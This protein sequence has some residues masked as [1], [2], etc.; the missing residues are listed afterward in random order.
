MTMDV[1]EGGGSLP[2]GVRVV[3]SFVL[4]ETP[5]DEAARAIDQVLNS[6]VESRIVL[7]DNSPEP[8][9]PA[10]PGDARVTQIHAGANLGYGAGHNRAMAMSAGWAPYHFV[11][12]TDLLYGPEVIPA[13]L[14][15]LDVHPEVGLAMP[16]VR[17]PDGRV[18]HLCRLLPHPLDVFGRGFASGSAWTRRR[19][20]RYE[21][22]QW[23]YDRPAEFPFL[24]G[25]FM[26]MRRDVV[27]RVG[28]FDDRFFMYGEDVDLS[29]RIHAIAR[30]MF[31]P[32]ACVA[33]DYRSQR[34]RSLRRT[35]YK[36][37]NLSRYF[38]KWGWFF[39]RNRDAIN[40]RTVA[41][42]SAPQTPKA[43]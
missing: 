15:F 43:S 27:D 29:R 32:V 19:N 12:N 37:A 23:S 28:G 25:C 7:I 14:K 22:R 18:Q 21:S 4:Y 6:P 39:D 31:A 17:Y 13:L 38:R 1:S 11:L 10:R 42:L 40:V 16:M 33:H 35:W 5:I 9:A 20:D 26:A 2:N 41:A 34:A 30:T 8:L 36:V 24:S 3:V